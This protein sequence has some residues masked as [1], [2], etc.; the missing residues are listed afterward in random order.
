MAEES[1]KKYKIQQAPSFVDD[2][3]EM[4][5]YYEYILESPQVADRFV[6]RIQAAVSSLKQ[7]PKR[8]QTLNKLLRFQTDYRYLISENQLL[9]YRVDERASA[10][11][12]IRLVDGRSDYVRALTKF[13]H[14]VMM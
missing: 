9:I 5:D 3:A 8:G 13:L 2:I 10:V 6:E 12:L 7:F 1:E 11:F 4:A 14:H